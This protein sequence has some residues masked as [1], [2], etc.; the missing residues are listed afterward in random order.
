MAK[1]NEV[2]SQAKQ[3]A[4]KK[5]YCQQSIEQFFKN[6]LY[7]KTLQKI[8]STEVLKEDP[9]FWS[10]AISILNYFNIPDNIRDLTPEK[11]EEIECFRE[12]KIK[13]NPKINIYRV[14][15]SNSLRDCCISNLF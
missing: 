3:D 15:A 14:K 12:V 2:L 11:I 7:K 4:T 1:I 8:L 5:D 6:C 10:E 13:P 9:N